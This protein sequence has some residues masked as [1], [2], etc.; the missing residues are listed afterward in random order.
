LSN[1]PCGS[2]PPRCAQWPLPALVPLLAYPCCLEWAWFPWGQLLSG[3]SILGSI[4][5]SPQASSQ[6]FQLFTRSLL[7]SWRSRCI[8]IFQL[9]GAK[10]PCF[11]LFSVTHEI[12]LR[13]EASESWTVGL[14]STNRTQYR[15]S[16]LCCLNFLLRSFAFL[17]S[18]DE[19]EYHCQGFQPFSTII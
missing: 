16:R 18:V 2:V 14:R 17:S 3:S 15:Q 1:F 6:N 12:L 8:D 19:I 5:G 4:A 13:K 7:Y 11:Q 9:R 10:E